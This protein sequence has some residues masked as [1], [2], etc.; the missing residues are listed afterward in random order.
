MPKLRKIQ[1]CQDVSFSQLDVQ[2]QCKP[3]QNPGKL[4]CTYQQTDSKIYTE[5]QKIHH[6]Q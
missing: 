1:C 4:F 2:I 3:N 5:R 6:S